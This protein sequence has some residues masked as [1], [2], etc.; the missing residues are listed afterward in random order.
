MYP[1]TIRQENNRYGEEATSRD[2]AVV[3]DKA[4]AFF[5]RANSE[6]KPFFLTIGYIDPHRH[7][8]QRGGFGNRDG[9]DPR[10]K[11]VVYDPKVVELP[12]WISDVPEARQEIA[13]YYRS[14]NRLDQGVG[15]MIEA[16]KAHDVYD[17]TLIIF[18]S[19]NGPP[20][21]NSKT[22]LYDAGVCLPLIVR[23]PL[24]K[25]GIANPNLVSYIDLLP[26]MLDYAGQSSKTNAGK[27]IG[28]SLLPILDRSSEEAEWGLVFGSH[29]LHEITNYWPT[30]FL[31]TRKYKYHRNMRPESQF[32]FAADLYASYSWEGL[33]NSAG[34]DGSKIM[35]GRRPLKAYL[36]RPAEELYDM[37]NDP[38]EVNNL[39]ADP[40]HRRTLV[41][42]RTRLER[43]QARTGDPFLLRDGVSLTAIKGYVNAGESIDIPDRF[44]MPVDRPGSVN[45]PA[46]KWTSDDVGFSSGFWSC[47]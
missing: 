14:I 33:R 37:E 40:Q 31:R 36:Q 30:R 1:W 34:G 25:A 17:D 29:T 43:W 12:S 22:T 11:D 26:T 3:A 28:R 19:D 4:S 39:A 8:R 20:F 24:Q 16:L 18:L 44:Y 5:A 45:V 32:P 41:E 27:R 6:D 15:L 9:F 13:E 38:D 35:L 42:M 46:V 21:V 10:I 47:D 2:T 7:H 23:M